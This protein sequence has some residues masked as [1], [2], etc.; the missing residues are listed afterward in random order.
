[1]KDCG[2][3]P[4]KTT[5]YRAPLVVPVIT[6][7]I[8]DGGVL[9]AGGRI[10][11]VDRFNRLRPEADRVVELEGRV[12]TPALINCHCH[13]E[14]SYLAPLGREGAF[15]TG[16]LTAWIRALLARRAEAT[17]AAVIEA[18]GRAA[19]AGLH[20]RGVAL[21]ADIGNLPESRA[22]GDS[23][24]TE[25]LFFQELLGATAPGAEAALATLSAEGRY[26][27]HAPYSCHPF[28]IRA[29][30]E[31]SR[32]AGGLFSIH[33]AESRAEIE[34]LERGQ[35]PFQEFL[36]ERLRQVGALS[37]DQE[38]T[39][40]L[41]PAGL[42]AVALLNDLHCLDETTLCVHAVHV[43]PAEIELIAGSRAKVCLCPGSNRRLGVGKAPVPH[44]IQAG[45]L[46]ALG[47][48]SLTS[49]TCLDLWQEMRTLQEDHP[50][51]PA[52]LIF[53]M[54]SRGGAEALGV[55]DRLGGLAPGLE[56]KLLAIPFAGRESE[57]YPFLVNSG[58]AI[59]LSWLEVG[60][61]G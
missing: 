19:L 5:L 13:L 51:V 1:M 46:P 56:A 18:A 27:A 11:G 26:T 14:L 59:D 22:L 42:G 54:A 45:I 55:G 44:M 17:P 15:A 35:G 3:R 2:Q 32:K 34:F 10:V 20:R 7:A 21:V 43:T 12:I 50:E 33:V 36:S 53:R 48:D 49:N 57:V 31:R 29:L 39:D 25:H 4:E 28:L 47:T 38:L 61:E 16:D 58:E 37:A 30:K 60:D 9:V 24:R 52:E 40:L 23:S 8:S 41:P 6:P